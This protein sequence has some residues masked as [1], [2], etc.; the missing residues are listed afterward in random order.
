VWEAVT[1]VI[2]LSC[3]GKINQDDYRMPPSPINVFIRIDVSYY[4]NFAKN[5][6][7]SAF[8]CLKQYTSFTGIKEE[9][10]W[11]NANTAVKH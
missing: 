7:R 3:A 1:L 10:D 9:N 5:V 8:G 6:A 11:N 2:V 4:P